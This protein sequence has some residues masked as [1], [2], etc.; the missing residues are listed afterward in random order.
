[1]GG[2]VNQTYYASKAFVLMKSEKKVA[3]LLPIAMVNRL[4][5]LEAFQAQVTAERQQIEPTNTDA[6]QI[7]EGQ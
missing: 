7:T 4:A 2:Y 5:E 1:M 3:A 6:N